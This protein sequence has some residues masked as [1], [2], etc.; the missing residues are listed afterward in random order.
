[1]VW[2][3]GLAALAGV[4]GASDRSDVGLLET[5]W[6]GLHDSTEQTVVNSERGLA[7]WTEGVEH[8]V[9]TVVAPIDVPSL[10]QHVL[11]LEE[12]FQDEP[13]QLRRQ[14]VLQLEPQGPPEAAV[15]VH[16]FSF[17]QPKQ[18]AH[19]DR[20]PQRAGQLKESDLR[21]NTD[22]DLVLARD[23][24]RF[25]GG[26]IGHACE[27]EHAGVDRYV[28]YQLVIGK[29]VYWYHRRVLRRHSDELRE[30]VI[31]YNW[32][33][34][35][36]AQL[37]TC[38]IDWSPTGRAVDLKPLQRIDLRDQ[39]GHAQ[40]STPDGHTLELVLHSQDWPFLGERDALILMV[41]EKR[42]VL[43]AST[44]G[45][46][47]GRLPGS[48]PAAASVPTGSVSPTI[49]SAWSEIDTQQIALQLDWLRVRCG[50]PV[51][52]TDELIGAVRGPGLSGPV[53]RYR[54]AAPG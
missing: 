37:F 53:S 1:M 27:D 49:G 23:G 54:S 12:F 20:R 26:T 22:C 3:A 8:R 17:V 4:A 43:Q 40:F 2:L 11:Y 38:R 25:I 18:W 30:E 51:P 44:G 19:L 33:Q 42:G 46:R 29:D 10:G 7:S 48:A 21:A 31:G 45:A 16:L 34:L 35:N 47:E 14:L 6:P 52:D 5:L 28:D 24:E 9:R 32:F 36:D 39:G 50:T 41:Q 13:D 15:R